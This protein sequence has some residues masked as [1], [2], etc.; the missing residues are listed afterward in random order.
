MM[1]LTFGVVAGLGMVF[2]YSAA[3]P[4]AIKWFEPRKKGLIAGI[5]VAE[6]EFLLSTWLR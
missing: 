2:A 6:L 4:A 5:V 3:T 1:V